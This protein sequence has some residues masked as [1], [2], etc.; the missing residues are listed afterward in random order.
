MRR[1]LSL[2]LAVLLVLST[3]AVGAFTVYAEGNSAGAGSSDTSGDAGSD[4]VAGVTGTVGSSGAGSYDAEYEM[5]EIPAAAKPI[6][7]A[8]DFAAMSAIG[9]Y[10]LANDITVSETYSYLTLNVDGETEE[11]YGFR[12]ILY[13]N[14]KTITTSVPLFKLLYNA[15]V[16]DIVMEG[17]V[18]LPEADHV[19][20]LAWSASGTSVY[21]VTNNAPISAKA[22]AAGL[23]GNIY[24]IC[25]F[26]FCVNN[27]PITV[28]RYEVSGIV[29]TYND[30]NGAGNAT[31]VSCVNN[32]TLTATSTEDS[33]SGGII[34]WYGPITY[35]DPAVPVADNSLYVINCVNTGDVSSQTRAAG[36]V[37]VS[38]ATR[39]FI[40]NCVNTG[41]ITSA[42]SHAGGLAAWVKNAADGS[43]L[44]ISDSYNEGDVDAMVHNNAAGGILGCGEG[45]LKTLV[46]ENC[47]N[48]GKST[49]ARNG[50]IAGIACAVDVT[51]MN[52]T[53]SGDVM[54]RSNYAA[55]IVSR[56]DATGN[57][58]IE[59]CLNAEDGAVTAPNG[60]NYGGGLL[61]YI[62][63]YNTT[64]VVVR[65][66]KNDAPITMNGWASGLISNVGTVNSFLVEN[67]ENN[68]KVTSASSGLAG[69]IVG[70]ANSNTDFTIRGC[71]NTGNLYVTTT[72]TDTGHAAG[73]AAKIWC[74]NGTLKV[75]NC[76]NTGDVE[77]SI[78]SGGIISYTNAKYIVLTNCVNTG[79]AVTQDFAT[80]IIDNVTGN[81]VSLTATDCYNSGSIESRLAAGIVGKSSATDHTLVNCVNDGAIK[82]TAWTGGGI[83]AEIPMYGGSAT[84]TNCTNNG[85][86]TGAARM[87]GMIGYT[88]AVTNST[89]KMKDIT[90]TNCHNTAAITGAHQ[91]SAMVGESSGTGTYTVKN[92]S[93]TAEI[94]TTNKNAG[95]IGAFVTFASYNFSDF[96]NSGNVTSATEKASGGIARSEGS[97]TLK[98]CYNLGNVNGNSETGGL[99]GYN[100]S[101]TATNLFENCYNGGAI[102]NASGNA[103]GGIVGYAKCNKATFKNC[104][105]VGALTNKGGVMGGIAGCSQKSSDFIT[106]VNMADLTVGGN[107]STGGILGDLNT[108]AGESKITDC[109]SIGNITVQKTTNAGGIIGYANAG[110]NTFPTMTGCAVYGNITSQGGG[111]G[112]FL[113]YSN[114]APGKGKIH[115]NIYVGKLNVT[116]TPGTGDF[117][118]LVGARSSSYKHVREDVKNNYY[119]LLEGST[120]LTGASYAQTD[121]VNLALDAAQDHAMTSATQDVSASL[122]SS[123]TYVAADKAITFAGKSVSGV[124]P[125][126][127]VTLLSTFKVPSA[128]TA[129][130]VST[131]VECGTVEMLQGGEIATEEDFLSMVPG[132]DYTLTADITL[133]QTYKGVFAGTLNGNGFT[134]TL[135]GVPAFEYLS[136]AVISDLTLA[137]EV[138]LPETLSVGALTYRAVNVTLD[139]VTNNANVTGLA[140]VGG[141]TGMFYVSATVIDCV[142]NGT[143][144]AGKWE[145]AGLFAK[146]QGV[147]MYFEGSKNNGNV[148]GAT[149]GGMVGY[150]DV[151][152][153]EGIFVNCEN[154]GNLSGTSYAGGI[155]GQGNVLKTLFI[156]DSKNSGAITANSSR[157]GGMLGSL[158]LNGA[159]C[160]IDNC[161]NTGNIT[162]GD[163]AGGIAGC[164]NAY[165]TVKNCVNEGMVKSTS[166][167]AGGIVSRVGSNDD[168][169]YNAN[170]YDSMKLHTFINCVNKG[171]VSSHR[172]QAAGILAVTTDSATFHNCL[173]EGYVHAEYIDATPSDSC[174]TK[175]CH[176]NNNK[177][178]IVAGGIAGR[179]CFEGT[180]Y[181]C[182]NVGNVSANN[183]VGGIA[184]SVGESTSSEATHGPIGYNAFIACYN[185]G[186]LYNSGTYADSYTC[187]TGGLFGRVRNDSQHK[188]LVVQYCGIAGTIKAEKTSVTQYVT[189]G[190][191]GSYA[192]SGFNSVKNNYVIADFDLD[193]AFTLT[194]LPYAKDS[195]FKPVNYENNFAVKK[196][197]LYYSASNYGYVDLDPA[198]VI[199]DADEAIVKLNAILG[200]DAFAM[201]TFANGA[202]IPVLQ[203]DKLLTPTTPTAINTAEEFANMDPYGNYYL[204]AD[205]TVTETY[206]YIFGGIF[207]GSGHTV[208]V[209]APLFG[210]LEGAEISNVTIEGDVTASVTAIGALAND[211]TDVTLSGIVNKANVSN[212]RIDTAKESNTTFTGGIIGTASGVITVNGCTNYG[213]VK[214]SS[215]GGFFGRVAD[216]DLTVIDS[217]NVGTVTAHS[218]ATAGG[219]FIGYT[220]KGNFVFEDCANNGLISFN[221]ATKYTARVGGFIGYMNNALAVT[222]MKNCVNAGTI[223]GGDQVA[224]LIGWTKGTVEATDCVNTGTIFSWSNYAGGLFGRVEKTSVFTNCYNYGDVTVSRQ[225]GGGIIGYGP[226][227]D[228][229]FVE[230]FNMGK[231]T[232]VVDRLYNEAKSGDYYFTMGGI[233]GAIKNGDFYHCVNLGDVN[234]NQQVGGIV[235]SLATGQALD[236]NNI[237]EGC[238]VAGNL[239]S[240]GERYNAEGKI[241]SDKSHGVGGLF[242]YSNGGGGTVP[243]VRNN[244]IVA[245]LKLDFNHPEVTASGSIPLVAGIASYYNIG[246]GIFENNV[247]AGTLSSNVSKIYGGIWSQNDAVTFSGNYL[248]EGNPGYAY[249]HGHHDTG[250]NVAYDE[251]VIKATDMKDGT[252]LTAIGEGFVQVGDYVISEDA[253]A[254]YA[255]ANINPDTYLPE[256]AEK[257]VP[258]VE[259]PVTETETSTEQETT[260][261]PDV[262]TTTEPD[263]ETTTEPD[264]ETTT[265]PDADTTTEPDVETTTEPD[266]DTTTEPGD[267]T[268]AEPE[269]VTTAGDTT[270]EQGG[271]CGS[272]IG[273]SIALVAM[274]IVSPAA[275]MLKKRED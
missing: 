43:I 153:N 193:P 107:G 16:R 90:L 65:N 118:V 81:C 66:C 110:G 130:K 35:G 79:N 229:V 211:A 254:I 29:A 253:A 69:G 39:T 269:D 34:G 250:T 261:A 91:T 139:G 103:T 271:G 123:F 71:L 265:E 228:Y 233:A 245:N 209:K 189:V 135:S 215:V 170:V 198:L 219:G 13:G 61:G 232:A 94:K 37:G 178:W 97:L 22:Q 131:D 46:I 53:N 184:G 112:L 85:V 268:T 144:T 204:A 196:T 105:N 260:T 114:F 134:V 162:A 270:E 202:K 15:T 92:C 180:F 40:Q 156:S 207:N 239:Y 208:T 41:N 117:A 122:G 38:Y 45:G 218:A 238:F 60:T 140:Y 113:A 188:A 181:N 201:E 98:N 221:N 243:I 23:I 259:P 93:N 157:A 174:S 255:L 128:P 82:A 11:E 192:N 72:S 32:G 126:S 67:C 17:S 70:G 266:V 141:F 222:T 169:I 151:G 194:V 28:A 19:G 220:G 212:T 210:T 4:A 120:A 84:L 74:S 165:T 18:S 104:I 99:V 33:N 155:V 68:G 121:K 54:T 249:H 137:G 7:T 30:G 246:G 179:V 158:G 102:N 235:G 63:P 264:V 56:V 161:T 191:L 124:L 145:G 27:A 26:E 127:A 119:F 185:A 257:P 36:L 147:D 143:I 6:R 223:L 187:G 230:C 77:K 154:T 2:A 9:V 55:G 252:L 89:A 1:F 51:I 64:D 125:S 80:G 3:C 214:G 62:Q 183:R 248:V 173:N 24:N 225:F 116:G 58:L 52:C 206:K 76:K 216:A 258:P 176:N 224:G 164:S 186:D 14:G 20:V 100:A 197:G 5:P 242:G 177:H 168:K 25:R 195:A 234:G 231:I 50:G 159:I 96:Y 78:Y 199:A 31:F 148:T 83:V 8:E 75:E 227:G 152:S 172:Q 48:V 256:G 138:N 59:N 190:A 263:V 163:Q 262:E 175:G 274:A 267:V 129:D 95:G 73:I 273:A 213:T 240:S 87:A 166:N 205:I 42:R 106:C 247:F 236:K 149:L 237:L 272:V 86:L 88:S 241:A 49:G 171:E 167:Y 101:T 44:F 244:V 150:L 47:E 200:P 12:G 10:Y 251:S 226:S 136:G 217:Y 111:A 275:L 133:T 146:G 203:E 142:N 57:I 115:N 182:V 160:V 132:G 108:G 109:V 21:G